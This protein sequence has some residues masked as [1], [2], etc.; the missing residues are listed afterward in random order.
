MPSLT[1][2][3]WPNAG[4]LRGTP[5]ALG[6]TAWN[7][8][9]P[10]YIPPEQG[11][12]DGTPITDAQVRFD[13][14]TGQLPHNTSY[15]R[16]SRRWLDYDKLRCMR[17]D[18]TIA[19]A[20]ETAVAPICGSIWTSELTDKNVSEEQKVAVDRYILP[21]RQRWLRSAMLGEI[22]FGWRAYEK[23]FSPVR[24]IQ[25]DRLIVTP[26]KIKALLN[27][28]TWAKYN[29]EGDFDGLLH[30]DPNGHGWFNIDYNH[31]LFC[32][33]DDDDLGNYNDPR[34]MRIESAYDEWKAANSAAARF[35][36]KM[37][38]AVWVVH[39]PEG[40][41]PMYKGQANVDNHEVARD[42]VY[43]IKASGH[44]MIPSRLLANVQE[45]IENFGQP[46]WKI[47]LLECADKQHG[48]IERLEH[49]DRQKIRGLG[50]LERAITE[51]HYGTK[52]ESES[53][54]NVMLLN[55]HLK[56]EDLTDYFNR[57]VVDQFTYLNWGVVGSV[58]FIAQPLAD[59]KRDLL[60]ALFTQ[61]LT[62]PNTE[63]DITERINITEIM[64][65]LK[66][67]MLSEREMADKA[68]ALP[69]LFKV[70]GES[71]NGQ[72]QQQ[73]NVQVQGTDI[74]AVSAA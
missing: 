16:F 12:N 47:E 57:E 11:S 39:Y 23:V 50:V 52:A 73:P 45:Q 49:L 13:P 18:P 67:P 7:T 9:S 51:G 66:L 32:N 35:D 48:F 74:S 15:N 3:V 62:N 6:D 53:H 17:R 4:A 29:K 21:F 40:K 8:N 61:L 30:S 20:R 69:A 14:F 65:E 71:T 25:L 28:T 2:P 42:I 38:G 41:Q 37:A 33:F 19:L 63:L 5:S 58:K 36:E 46:A 22:D 55:M 70:I 44:L 27:D 56:H 34:L 24:D 10:G 1:V 43:Q 26:V 60:I 31:S 72:V 54:I 64:R 59:A 68:N